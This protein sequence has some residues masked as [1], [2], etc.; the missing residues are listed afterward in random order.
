MAIDEAPDCPHCPAQGVE[1]GVLG[2][3][4]HF[5]CPNC[6]AQFWEGIRR[7]AAP[8]RTATNGVKPEQEVHD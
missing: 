1:L 6:G 7:Q 2:W 3:T 5:R 4:R 8:A